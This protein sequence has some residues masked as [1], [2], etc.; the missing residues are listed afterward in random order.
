MSG[1]ASPYNALQN[2]LINFIIEI[3]EV[4]NNDADVGDS[5]K[6]VYLPNYNV[7]LAE[8]IF[9][10]LDIFQ[11]LKVPGIES[12]HSISGMK[13][14]V[15]GAMFLSSR[16]GISEQVRMIYSKEEANPV[17]LFGE[18]DDWYRSGRA[19]KHEPNER[20]KEVLGFIQREN[21]FCRAS[22]QL[23]EDICLEKGFGVSEA[24]NLSEVGI[25]YDFDAYHE[26]NE[27]LDKLW[28]AGEVGQGVDSEGK[29]HQ[30][31]IHQFIRRQLIACSQARQLSSVRAIIDMQDL[32][33]SVPHVAVQDPALFEESDGEEGQ[34]SNERDEVP[35]LGG[36]DR[37]AVSPKEMK[38]DQGLQ[39]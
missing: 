32:V 18:S 26:A 19:E 11:N 33:W 38:A 37:L 35:V 34:V 8:K 10:A 14:L 39:A 36:P 7:S 12:E 1:K 23:V 31:M 25:C 13:A 24:G 20:L 17:E 22:T 29:V 9:P 3:Q 28:T 5:L 6:V 30:G 15:N 27:R 16:T 21:Q 4:I 2:A